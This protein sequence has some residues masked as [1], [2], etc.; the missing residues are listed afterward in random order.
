MPHTIDAECARTVRRTSPFI[1]DSIAGANAAAT[2]SAVAAHEPR[3]RAG[4][5]GSLQA[6][7][8]YGPMPDDHGTE[9]G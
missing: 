5:T 7:A 9:N 6:A 3:A 8:E 1:D 2:P 4:V